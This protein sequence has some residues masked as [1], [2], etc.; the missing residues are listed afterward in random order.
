M[1]FERSFLHLMRSI[2]GIDVGTNMSSTIPERRR[3]I[4]DN[5]VALI[6]QIRPSLV[7]VVFA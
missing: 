3:G 5:R 4:R 2:F 7:L 1:G 6:A